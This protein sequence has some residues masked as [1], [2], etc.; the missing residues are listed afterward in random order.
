MTNLCFGPSQFEKNIQT[1]GVS[2]CYNCW[3]HNINKTLY[4]TP[5][6]NCPKQFRSYHFCGFLLMPF[7]CDQIFTKFWLPVVDPIRWYKIANYNFVNRWSQSNDISKNPQKPL[8]PPKQLW[9]ITNRWRLSCLV[10]IVFPT[11]RTACNADGLFV[12]SN[13]FSPKYIACKIIFLWD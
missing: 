3:K 9:T 8:L 13:W 10:N 7:D 1:I 12:F 6:R 11:I 4:S 5:I 2:C